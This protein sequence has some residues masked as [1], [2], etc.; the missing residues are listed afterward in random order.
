MRVSYADRSVS[1]EFITGG[2]DQKDVAV[3]AVWALP[4]QSELQARVQYEN[5]RFPVLATGRQ[6]NVSA[7]LQV[8]FRPGRRPR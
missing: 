5:W 6:S 3:Q 2:G 4:R 1:S 7:F 8:T